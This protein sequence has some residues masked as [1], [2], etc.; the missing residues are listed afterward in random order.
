MCQSYCLLQVVSSLKVNQAH[1]PGAEKA[2]PL[3]LLPPSAP[4]D[5]PG[6]DDR[7]V[8]KKSERRRKATFDFVQEGSF[9]KQAQSMR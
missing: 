6:F 4:E 8:S 2:A 7:M 1:L 5:D 3:T 9:Q